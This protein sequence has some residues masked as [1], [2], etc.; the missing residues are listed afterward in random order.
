MADLKDRAV[1]KESR[2]GLTNAFMIDNDY[3]TFTSSSMI[4]LG[5]KLP[6]RYFEE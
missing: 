5:W 4:K 3:T 1:T 6:E 2:S